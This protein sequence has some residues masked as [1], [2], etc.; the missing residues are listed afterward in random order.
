[1]PDNP[2]AQQSRWKQAVY[3]VIFEAD[4]HAGQAFDITLLW[5]I[6]L[7]VLVVMLES[8]QS[9]NQQY[10]PY[11]R[12]LEW[13]FTILF[14]IEYITRLVVVRRPLK[15][16]FSFLGII[17]FLA[18]V[19]T[20][21]SLL[22]VGSQYLLIIRTIRLL[23]VFRI[24]KL[25][26]FVGEAAVITGALKASRHKILVFLTSV[27]AMVVITGTL[28]YVIEGGQNG[29]SSIPQSIYWAIVTLTTVGYGDISPTTT[30][31][32]ALASVIMIMGYAII[33]VPTGIVTAELSRPYQKS[34]KHV[35]CHVCQA[36]E[37]EEDAAFC[38]KCGEKL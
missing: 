11:L 32:K 33:A 6:L 2:S 15:Y 16:A 13:F 22:I 17:D 8:V 35:I 9:V 26:R 23:R 20:F 14:T 18:I 4:T 10:G 36:T 3:Q 12:A 38:R 28:M 21:L 31:G 29:F 19:P 1:M 30:L 34:Y 37:H 5:A 7:S 24:L 25:S 27:V